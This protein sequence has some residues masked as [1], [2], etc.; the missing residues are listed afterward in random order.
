MRI[1]H[2]WCID[3]KKAPIKTMVRVYFASYNMEI[4]INKKS[5]VQFKKKL[6]QMFNAMRKLIL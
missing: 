5:L 1:T 4:I 3:K 2:L 6:Q